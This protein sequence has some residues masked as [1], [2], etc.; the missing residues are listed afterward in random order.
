M[1]KAKRLYIMMT[2]GSAVGVIAA[3]WQTLDK[4]ALLKNPAQ[5]LSCNLSSVFSCSNV[6]NSHQA[7]VFGFPNSIMCLALFLILLTVA[8]V[9]LTGGVISKSMRFATQFLSLFTLGF[10]FWF[11]F[12]STYRIHAICIFCLF[13]F[14]GLLLVNASWLRINSAD[15]KWMKRLTARG[16]D[17]FIWVLA[18]VVVSAAI[19]FKFYV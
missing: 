13:C 1:K 11:L 9:G 18:A 7:S 8:V 12:E 6:L 15:A 3:F 10:A 2:I 19:A 16:L 4:L 5:P 14:A 17:W